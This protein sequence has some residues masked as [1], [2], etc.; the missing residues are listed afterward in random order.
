MTNFEAWTLSYLLNSLWQVPLLFAAGW[1]AARALRRIGPEAE[2]RVWAAV[3][4]LQSLLPACSTLQLDWLPSLF[5]LFSR[6]G[7]EGQVSVIVGPGVA[8]TGVHLPNPTL[9]GIAVAYCGV[10]AWF[11]ARFAWRCFRLRRLRR[12]S[13][14]A[15]LSGDLALVANQA[16]AYFGLRHVSLA[17]SPNVFSPVTLGA[18]NAIVLLPAKNIDEMELAEFHAVIAHEFAHIRRGD[19]LRNIIC[20][21]LALPV[22]YHPLLWFTRE[23]LTETREMICDRMAA[24]ISGPR[25]YARSLLRLAS[26]LAQGIPAR[27]P[28]AVGIFDTNTLER[29]VMNLM[30]RRPDIRGLRRIAILVTLATFGIAT[31]ASALAMRMHV[32]GLA[33]ASDHPPAHPTHPVAVRPDIMAGQRISGPQPKYPEAAKKARIQGTV[34]IDAVIGKDGSVA[35]TKVTSGPKELRDSAVD[36]VQQWKYKPFLLNGEP[37]EVTTTISVVYS[38]AK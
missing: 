35:K 14:P 11:A 19:F 31:C 6:T 38:L 12:E 7:G 25:S 3:L 2:H 23:R 16:A 32:D 4:I 9:A 26:L 27:T 33:Q 24:E 15:N 28:H 20:E 37:V 18:S 8:W 30:E 10:T 1:L 13:V 34:K 17:T 21:F 22:S 29:R 5:S 36:A